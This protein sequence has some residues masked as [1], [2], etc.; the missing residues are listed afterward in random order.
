M[1][2]I[3]IDHD[4]ELVCPVCGSKQFS[5][6]RTRGAKL[7][8]GLTVGVAALAAPKRLQCLGCREYLKSPP[9]PMLGAGSPASIQGEVILLVSSTQSFGSGFVLNDAFRLA[10]IKLPSEDKLRIVEAIKAGK[11]VALPPV[12]AAAA[13]LLMQRF[14][15]APIKVE[16][17]QSDVDRGSEPSLGDRVDV[18]TQLERLASLRDKGF[19]TDA[20]FT[21]QKVALLK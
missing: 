7:A 11:V 3:L 8:A 4:G 19:L 6:R 18:V 12:S 15:K 10:K 20:E 1:K 5:N 2:H 16:I 14:E 17:Q 13:R 9:L 21:A